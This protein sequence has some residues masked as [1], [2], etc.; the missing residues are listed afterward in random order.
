MIRKIATLLLLA[1][2]GCLP[3]GRVYEKHKELSPEVQWLR[4]DTRTFEVPIEDNSVPYDMGLTFRFVNG[5]QY[6]H[7]KVKVTET[8]PSGKVTEMEY[9]MI[10]VDQN[11]DYIGEPGLD[12][13]DSEHKVAPSKT[14]EETGTY[15]YEIAHAMPRDTL[16]LAME[17]GIVLDK[18]K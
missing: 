18:A 5:Y 7:A 3:E 14:F 13:W 16:N 4:S 2:V 17:I 10:V 15:T 6:P 8:S 12:I 1:L 9:D 11:G